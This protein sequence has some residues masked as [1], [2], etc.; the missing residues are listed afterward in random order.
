MIIV[1]LTNQS[2]KRIVQLLTEKQAQRTWKRSLK[3]HQ[4]REVARVARDRDLKKATTPSTVKNQKK[5]R[6]RTGP[7]EKTIV[8]RSPWKLSKAK[9]WPILKLKINRSQNDYENLESH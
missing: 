3:R 7:L 8:P 9:A 1:S 4:V 2:R 6:V 5:N